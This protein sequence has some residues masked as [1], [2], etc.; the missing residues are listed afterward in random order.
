MIDIR[1]LSQ[2]YKGATGPVEALRGIDPEQ[3]AAGLFR[4]MRRLFRSQQLDAIAR[5]SAGTRDQAEV[6]LAYRL[7]W[8]NEL[9]LPEPPRH[10]LY[11]S[12]A[13]IRSGELD[14]ARASLSQAERGRPLLDY[15]A[16]CEFWVSYLRETYA[17]RFAALKDAFEARVLELI[18][19][20]PEDSAERSS[21]RVRQVE[22]TF[23]EDER[24]LID[25]LTIAERSLH[26]H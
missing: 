3:R 12:S 19:L 16:D 11:R 14:A 17:T 13:D 2:T 24:A 26:D 18:D 25:E 1:G 15:A 6:R 4:L 23:K 8:G 21:E 7:R 5:E 20:Y 10:M 22:A 9:D